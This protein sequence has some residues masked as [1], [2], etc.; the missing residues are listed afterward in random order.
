MNRRR[1]LDFVLYVAVALLVIALAVGLALSDVAETLAKGIMAG[2]LS[3][4][5]IFGALVQQ[6]WAY[7]RRLVF[8]LAM[9]VAAAVHLVLFSLLGGRL[10]AIWW[11]LITPIEFAVLAELLRRLVDSKPKISGAGRA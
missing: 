5:V 1:L 7:R 3:A 9:L 6:F 8:R 10:P 2:C 11:V 4:V